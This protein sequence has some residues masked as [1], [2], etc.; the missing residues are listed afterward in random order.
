ML[1]SFGRLRRAGALVVIDRFDE[2]LDLLGQAYD[3]P[4]AQLPPGAEEHVL[5]VDVGRCAVK[6][7]HTIRGGWGQDPQCGLLQA[8][9]ALAVMPVE[10]TGPLQ[11]Q[12]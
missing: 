4:V 9:R 6:D 11:D 3:V 5:V 8:R 10:A 2:R 1:E 7:G 12:I